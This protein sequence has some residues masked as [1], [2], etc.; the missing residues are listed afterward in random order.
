VL[1]DFD[2]RKPDSRREFLRV[3]RNGAGRLELFANQNSGVLTSTVW[4]E[5]LVDNPA[6]T[7]IARGDSVRFL[8]F[9]ELLT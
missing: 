4:A 1:A 7:L 3:R 6:Q 9:S 5:G 8:P 2:I